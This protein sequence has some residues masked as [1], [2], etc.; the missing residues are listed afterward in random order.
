MAVLAIG[1]RPGSELAR[2]AGLPLNKRGGIITDARMRTEDPSIYAVG[3][4]AEVKDLVF[5]EPAMIPLAGPANRQG[6]TAADN[7]AGRPAVYEGSLG[8]AVIKLFDLTAASSGM[9]EKALIARGMRRGTDY[10]SVL[11][12]QNDHAGYYPGATRLFIK[13]LFSLPEG[14]LLGAQALGEKG[15]DKRMDVLATAM[16]LNATVRDLAGWSCYAPP[17]PLPRIRE[18]GGLHGRESASGLDAFA[19]GI[20]PV[21]PG[22]PAAGRRE[23]RRSAKP[24]PG[25]C[26]SPGELRRRM[27]FLDKERPVIVFAPSAYG[28]TACPVCCARRDSRGSPS[29]R[30]AWPSTRRS[31]GTS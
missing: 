19:P 29:I 23:G 16:R 26:T 28:R 2:A 22:Q 12:A 7:I 5:G 17:T 4:A 1:V 11:V 18:H 13:L 14:R 30:A 3:D 8:S 24:R 21:G 27:D 15:V 20:R 25:R 6:R 31:A 10:D 9:N